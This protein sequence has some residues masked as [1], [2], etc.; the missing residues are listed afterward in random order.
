MAAG[1]LLSAL[2]V[3]CTAEKPERVTVATVAGGAA[4]FGIDIRQE[5]RQI[6]GQ[7]IQEWKAKLKPV[8][9]YSPDLV[10]LPEACDLPT[11][12]WPPEKK[13]SYYA[14]MGDLVL[15]FFKEAA[16]EQRCYMGLGTYIR[17]EDGRWYDSFVLIDRKGEI[18]GI[19]DKNYPTVEEMEEGFVPS[20]QLP[21]FDCD[22]GRVA[23]LICYDLNFDE[24]RLRTA[25]LKPDILL[26]SSMYHG[27]DFVQ[28]YWAY[29]CQSYFVSSQ[30][31]YNVPSEIRDPVGN[32][33][34]S[35]TNYTG[36]AVATITLDY[37]LVHVGG[38]KD[39]LEA[40]K[41]AYGDRVTITDPGNLAVVLVTSHHPRL[42]AGGM[43][44]SYG[45][46]TFGSLLERSRN[47]RLERLESGTP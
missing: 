40:L 22:F 7:V 47:R 21:V 39:K 25:A 44:S 12:K 2:P 28:D 24:L 30:F 17:K 37:Q 5:P 4:T 10:V 3:S 13:F 27:G 38:N 18:A 33:V 19:Y 26:F 11:F 41:A 16:R 43:L 34:A 9:V 6:A 1:F 46:E 32:V 45:I 14:E 42:S 29:T 31:N 36:Y 20:G 8:F 35:T 15:G 23:A